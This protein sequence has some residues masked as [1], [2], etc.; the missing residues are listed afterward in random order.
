MADQATNIKKL[1]TQLSSS[2][3]EPLKSKP[4][5]ASFKDRRNERKAEKITSHV[6]DG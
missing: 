5:I 2:Q 1:E 4:A 3:G 6:D